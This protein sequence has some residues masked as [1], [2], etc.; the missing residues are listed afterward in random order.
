LLNTH[1][2]SL[3]PESFFELHNIVLAQHTQHLDLPERGPA[4]NLILCMY[5]MQ[6]HSSDAHTQLSYWKPA[7]VPCS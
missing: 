1:Q 3:A 5:T 7:Q 6:T 4:N 2:L